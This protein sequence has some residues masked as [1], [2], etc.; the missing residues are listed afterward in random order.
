MRKLLC[1]VP[2][3]SFLVFLALPAWGEETHAAPAAPSAVVGALC[4]VSSLPG[5][6]SLPD[7]IP[8]PL[9][10]VMTCGPCS[11]TCTALSPGAAC[12]TEQNEAGLCFGFYVGSSPQYC[13]GT[14][15]IKCVCNAFVE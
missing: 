10:A 12:L 15:L 5:S 1:A 13:P 8:A 7:V 11:S 6:V 14:H 4:P 3:L 9:L 2:V